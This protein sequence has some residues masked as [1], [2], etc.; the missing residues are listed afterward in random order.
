MP[1]SD[2]CCIIAIVDCV[3]LLEE[4]NSLQPI[5]LIIPDEGC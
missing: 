2:L 5:K 4:V 1:S 3:L